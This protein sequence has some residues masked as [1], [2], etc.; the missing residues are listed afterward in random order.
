V[1]VPVDHIQLL[2]PHDQ[3]PVVIQVGASAA[4]RLT[5]G[6]GAALLQRLEQADKRWVWPPT[7]LVQVVSDGGSGGVVASTTGWPAAR[8]GCSA[9]ITSHHLGRH[10]QPHSLADAGHGCIGV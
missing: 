4:Q 5:S 6:S 9:G 8:A 2:Q 3:R 7:R 1:H 10:V